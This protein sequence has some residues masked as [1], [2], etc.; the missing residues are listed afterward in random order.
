MANHLT[1]TELADE[2]D[3]K[4]QEVIARCV[5]M[6]VPILHG[7]DRQDAV[8]DLAAPARASTRPASAPPEAGPAVAGRGVRVPYTD[9][10][11]DPTGPERPD[12]EERDRQWRQR[13]CPSPDRR[14]TGS[15]T[16]ADLLPLAAERYGDAPAVM[17]EGAVRRLGQPLL[18]GGRRDSSSASR[19]GLIDLGIEKGDKVS[20]LAN[21][22]PEWTYVDFAALSVGATVVPIYQTNSAEECQYVLENSDAR[23][24]IVENEEQLAKIRAVRD[25]LPKLEQ[26]VIMEGDRGRRDRP[27]RAPRARRRPRAQRVGGAL[28]VGHARRHLHLHLHVG[29]DRPAEGLR[30][31]PR[32]LPGDAR[33]DPVGLG[34][35]AGRDHLPLPPP[36]PLLR[37]AAAARQL[38]HR[39]DARLLGARP[40]EDHPQPQRG[41]AALLPVGAADLREDLHG[42]DRRRRQGGRPQEADLLVGDR[43]RHRRC[44]RWSG[45]ARSPASCS[46][47]STSSPT[48]RCSRRSATCSA[49]GSASASAAR[50]RSTPTSSGSSTPPASSSSRATG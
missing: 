12:R 20:I 13:R 22:R 26:V 27:R 49:A 38:R 35:R 39:G 10:H 45:A 43:R 40:A 37:A 32:Q 4:R 11:G 31:Q 29:H 5:Q 36:R 28:P 15:N 6:G 44:A 23:L 17:L 8:H 41:P 30:D 18:R 16:V 46:P 1:P 7:Q 48:P 34:R 21:T 24:V 14:G 2:V 33:H 47:A 42:R 50:R 25:R 9:L 3:M 19:S